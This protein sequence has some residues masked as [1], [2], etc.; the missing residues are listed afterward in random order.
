MRKSSPIPNILQSGGFSFHYYVGHYLRLGFVWQCCVVATIIAAGMLLAGRLDHSWILPGQDVGLLE[1]PA[2]WGFPLLQIIVPLC[3]RQSLQKFQQARL[4][5]GEIK[6][7]EGKPSALV[8]PLRKFL[9]WHDKASKIAATV[10]YLVG[11]TA[12]AW[13]TIQNQRPGIVVPYDFWDSKHFLWGFVYT[14]FYKLYLFGWF[15]PYIGMIQAGILIVTLRFVRRA[16]V[17]GKLRLFP[18]HP[19][20]VGGLDFVA[21]L[22]STPVIITLVVGSLAT[23]VVFFAHGGIAVTPIMALV[24]LIGWAFLAY[25]VPILFLRSDIVAMKREA[26]EKLR[27]LQQENYWQITQTHGH[28]VEM[29]GKGKEALDYFDKVCTNIQAISNYPHLRRLLSLFSLSLLPSFVQI[30]IKL[31][32]NV[33][34]LLG[35]LLKAH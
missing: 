3:I 9:G 20:G 8:Q 33:G 35:P 30:G 32:Q 28:D 23:A 1:H 14:R 11:F 6:K 24:V 10:I 15:L 21:S 25:F 13:N 16:R 18:F 34:P 2:L 17:T 5:K 31:Y 19:D 26:L 22:I 4:H 12:I 7:V 27:G 29:L